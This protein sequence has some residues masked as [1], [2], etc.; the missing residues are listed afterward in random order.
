MVILSSLE[1][2]PPSPKRLCG[3]LWLPP[4]SF[5]LGN[6]GIPGESPAIPAPETSFAIERVTLG[7]YTPASNRAP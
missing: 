2:T 7:S 6:M 4:S 5:A 1:D 3:S